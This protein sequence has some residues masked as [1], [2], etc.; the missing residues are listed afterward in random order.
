MPCL[1]RTVCARVPHHITQRGDRC[2][3][4]FWTDYDRHVYLYWLKECAEKYAVDILAYGLMTTHIHLVAVQA[5][6]C[7]DEKIPLV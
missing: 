2:E 5:R 7:A 4:V 6:R 3:K 1:A